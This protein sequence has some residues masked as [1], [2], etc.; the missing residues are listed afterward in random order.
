MKDRINGEF[1]LINKRDNLWLKPNL[2]Y[3]IHEDGEYAVLRTTQSDQ[4]FF[5]DLTVEQLLNLISI[6]TKLKTWD[7]L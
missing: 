1:I 2:I 4:I 3:K 5:S 6:G 7:E